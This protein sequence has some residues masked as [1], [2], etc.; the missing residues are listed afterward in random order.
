MAGTHCH[1][2]LN[3]HGPAHAPCPRARAAP[4]QVVTMLHMLQY[5]NPELSIR[6]IVDMLEVALAEEER[7]QGPASAPRQLSAPAPPQVWAS[8]WR[9]PP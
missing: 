6:R 8:R 9:C 5:C 7:P 2:P 3:Q 1:L 4:V